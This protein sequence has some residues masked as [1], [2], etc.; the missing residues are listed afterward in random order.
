MF[1]SPGN[2]LLTSA[3]NSNLISYSTQNASIV[4][5]GMSIIGENSTTPIAPSQMLYTNG[6]L[7]GGGY[8]PADLTMMNRFYCGGITK[9]YCDCA[10]PS[11]SSESTELMLINQWRKAAATNYNINN[12]NDSSQMMLGGIK[13]EALTNATATHF[14]LAAAGAGISLSH[15]NLLQQQLNDA[16][17]PPHPCG[18]GT[19]SLFFLYISN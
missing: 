4:L 5:S 1:L 16:Q 7:N 6:M 15:L 18:P 13:S 9:N 3:D 11:H 14:P 2:V 8:S 17:I 10:T 19:N 12:A